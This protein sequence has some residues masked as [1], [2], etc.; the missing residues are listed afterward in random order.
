MFHPNF[1]FRSKKQLQ[2]TLVIT[3]SKG[4]TEILRYPYLDISDLQ[5]RG[6]NKSNNHSSQMN[7]TIL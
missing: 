3:K 2:S 4:L 6:K 1:Y 5:N 7:M